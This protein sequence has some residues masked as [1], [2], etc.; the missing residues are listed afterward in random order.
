MMTPV[1]TG[2]STRTPLG[3]LVLVLLL[4][5]A[6]SAGA[7]PVIRADGVADPLSALVS[8]FV[9]EAARVGQQF[10]LLPTARPTS[11]GTPAAALTPSPPL[12]SPAPIPAAPP[13][14]TRPATAAP[15]PTTAATP[16]ATSAQI[17]VPS[18]SS[19][20][21]PRIP[22]P[23]PSSPASP[24]LPP[25]I[26]STPT[27]SWSTS[28]AVMTPPPPSQ[29]LTSSTQAAPPLTTPPPR[30]QVTLS[31]PATSSP[32][33][34]ATLPPNNPNSPGTQ[35]GLATAE[36]DAAPVTRGSSSSS[37]A[38]R[39]GAGA[40]HEE[41]VGVEAKGFDPA[42][43]AFLGGTPD[44]GTDLPV[45]AVF[46]LLFLAGAVTHMSIYRANARRGH[47]FLL[48]DLMFGF[49]MVRVATCAFRIAWVFA[50]LRGI[51]LAAVILQNS[52]AAV[53]FAV[54]IIFAQ[55]IARSLHP[56]F[57]WRR[58]FS[59]FTNAVTISVPLIILEQIGSTIAFFFSVGDPARLRIFQTLLKFG[60]SYVIFLGG[61]PLV[62]LGVADGIPGPLPEPFG[63]GDWRL[64]KS[65]VMV[66]GLLLLTGAAVRLAVVLN[67]ESPFAMSPLFSKATFYTTQSA[68]E[69]LVI[70]LYAAT[71]VDLLFHVPDG[72][73]RPGDYS[74]RNAAADSG[75]RPVVT[76][77]D[78]E[79][80]LHGLGVPYE[81]V[82]RGRRSTLRPTP[83]K[84]VVYAVL[85]ADEPGAGRRSSA[86][87][88]QEEPAEPVPAV[89]GVTRGAGTRSE[90]ATV[91]QLG[92]KQTAYRGSDWDYDDE[93]DSPL[94]VGMRSVPAPPPRARTRPR[95]QERPDSDTYTSPSEKEGYYYDDG[96]DDE[97]VPG[98]V[99]YAYPDLPPRAAPVS[100]RTSMLAAIR[101]RILRA[102]AAAAAAAGPEG[103]GP[104]TSARARHASTPR[105]AS[106][107]TFDENDSYY[108]GRRRAADDD[109]VPVPYLD[110]SRNGE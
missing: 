64:K 16:H 78:V 13:A 70:V 66:G 12:I 72:S 99:G 40:G 74:G 34:I 15:P 43:G 75:K 19:S 88:G 51:I 108:I 60:V 41:A 49:S 95:A 2:E 48:S 28:I 68:L 65:V 73:S 38:A 3:L 109:P 63:T 100:R 69:L 93:A 42:N 71:R 8:I 20:A 14:S 18:S 17:S 25:S 104:V 26:S 107:V 105:R 94:T 6:G 11:T 50:P 55:R 101:P 27:T 77:G 83:D 62:M 67:P 5:S 87:G 98:P 4:H 21:S 106:Y 110:G 56:R 37:P 35:P 1:S 23:L 90:A 9:S 30:S 81:I 54:N 86:G 84:A 47:K 80:T 103:G 44:R 85:Y 29:P 22:S 57:G 97:M 52:G 102:A 58:D 89:P 79:D 31:L 24:F 46:L 76:R 33:I 53:A 32:A 61:L 96:G 39:A 36:P 82:R 10:G 92:E 45:T 7:S 91:H 59:I